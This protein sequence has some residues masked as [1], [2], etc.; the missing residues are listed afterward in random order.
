LLCFW[1]PEKEKSEPKN[2]KLAEIS[3][4]NLLLVTPFLVGVT[5][6]RQKV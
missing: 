6:K 1:R 3:H 5:G 4:F 2:K